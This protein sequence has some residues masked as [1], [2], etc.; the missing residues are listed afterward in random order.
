LPG[1][2]PA[3]KKLCHTKIKD[4]SKVNSEPVSPEIN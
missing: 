4:L 3:I 2:A 1:V